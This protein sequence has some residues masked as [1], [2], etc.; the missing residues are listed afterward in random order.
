MAVDT[1]IPE[2]W[3]ANLIS[4]LE[5]ALVYGFAA[6][7]NY[8]GDIAQKGDTV[9][10]NAVTD[11]TVGDY[12][13]GSDIDIE[14]AATAEKGTLKIDQAKYFAFYADDVKKR[15]AA[16][17]FVTEATAK[18][19]YKLRDAADKFLGKKMS[20]KAGTTLTKVA[21]TDPAKAYDTLVDLA[22]AL[23]EKSAPTE[24]RWVV[25]TPAFYG[26]LRKDA[27]FVSGSDA[28]NATLH[29]GIVGSAAG[30]TVLESVN[31][32]VAG[33]GGADGNFIIAGTNGATTFAEQI[34]SVEAARKEKGFG[35]IVKGLHLYGAEV[36]LPE[37]LVRVAFKPTNEG[38]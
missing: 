28:A 37:A 20:D 19:A 6:N 9:H 4:T 13:A 30:L 34:V 15:Q 2:I 21:T 31:A 26:L 7:R 35:D 11:P 25:V 1:F 33:S 17:D 27:R 12:T 8:E 18:A 16:G 22:T 32:P 14:D 38:A 24:G 5:N 36:V 23:D 10:I 3:S 29:N